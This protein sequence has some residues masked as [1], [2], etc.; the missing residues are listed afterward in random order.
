MPLS[1]DSPG[2]DGAALTTRRDGRRPL[3]GAKEPS[4]L[5]S[6]PRLL[7]AQQRGR[8]GSCYNRALKDC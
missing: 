6:I 1:P 4:P 8:Q 5:R 7:K 3:T 2:A